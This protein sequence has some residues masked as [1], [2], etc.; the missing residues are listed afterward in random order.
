VEASKGCEYH[1]VQE[2]LH[3]LCDRLLEVDEPA[4]PCA[5]GLPLPQLIL[6][7]GIQSDDP[8]HQLLVEAPKQVHWVCVHR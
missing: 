2:V 3:T 7:S 5:L 4:E 1:G 8:V 6:P